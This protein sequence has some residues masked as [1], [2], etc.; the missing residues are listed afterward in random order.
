MSWKQVQ[1]GALETSSTQDVQGEEIKEMIMKLIISHPR[2]NIAASL[3]PL[4][5]LEEHQESMENKHV[6]DGSGRLLYWMQF[7]S[8]H[9]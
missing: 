3:C 6:C 9:L 4:S 1:C 2:A 8:I 5:Q 7:V